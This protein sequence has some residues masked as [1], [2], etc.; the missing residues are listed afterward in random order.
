MK[1]KMYRGALVFSTVTLAAMLA[2]C[3]GGGAD[4]GTSRFNTNPTT[5]VVTENAATM[6]TA[7]SK[8]S[9][10]NTDTEP[11]V[12]TI[13]LVDANGLAVS[14]KAVTVSVQGAVGPS[15]ALVTDASG[16]A[17]IPLDFTNDRSNRVVVAKVTAAGLTEEVS[18]AVTGVQVATKF[19][20]A[21]ISPAQSGQFEVDVKDAGGNAFSPTAVT[22][23]PPSGVVIDATQKLT[24]SGKAVFNYTVPSGFAGS[25]LAF[26]VSA[27]GFS[28]PTDP[29]VAVQQNTGTVAIQPAQGTIG[30]AIVD[31]SKTV[32]EVNADGGTAN[33]V[34][35]RFK[36]FN[37]QS[38]PLPMQNVRVSLDLNGDPLNVGGTLSAGRTLLYT[39]S[40]GVAATSYIPG[41]KSTGTSQLSIRACYS[42][43]D[44]TPDPEGDAVAG[45]AACPNA[46]TTSL[47]LTNAALNV[48]V[49]PEGLVAK[50]ADGRYSTDF[51]INVVN[52]A[53][54]AKSNVAVSVVLDL[55]GFEKGEYV[56]GTGEWVRVLSLPS[57]V[58]YADRDVNSIEYKGCINEDLNR[59]GLRTGAEDV[60]GD[61]KLEPAKA[62]ASFAFVDDRRLTD[63][64]G[65][66]RVRVTYFKDVAG[67]LRIKLYGTASVSGTE[68]KSDYVMLLLPV[69]DDVKAEGRPPFADNR[70]GKST[71]CTTH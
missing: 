9:V 44:F 24:S 29:V 8:V 36:A 15:T 30:T 12:A 7:I 65:S 49:A 17:A 10:Q 3:G 63:E 61:G 64:N 68:G 38:T 27:A 19:L 23:R 47:T 62:Q 54:E 13:Q 59:D 69:I 55:L 16:K 34:E 25:S 4:A 33:Q 6:Y 53:G 14:G 2:A 28:S 71:N 31:P 60:D 32:I 46:V 39:N 42:T 18:F 20:P 56:R 57:S 11:V 21:V 43:T 67:W 26:G 52:A 22:V 5:P 35:L 1:T 70:Y 51:V 58:T 66:V 40:E 45:S 41:A 37:N 50:T 48:D